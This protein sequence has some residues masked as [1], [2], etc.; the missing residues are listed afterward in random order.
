[1][2]YTMKEYKDQPQCT[3][4]QDLLEVQITIQLVGV[5]FSMPSVNDPHPTTLSGTV[6]FSTPYATPPHVIASIMEM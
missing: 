2:H 3:S 4:I 5:L 6:S 1:M